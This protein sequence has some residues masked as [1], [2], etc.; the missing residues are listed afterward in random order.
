MNYL[1][2][3]FPAPFAKD[4]PNKKSIWQKLIEA[5]CELFGFKLTPGS[6]LHKE[7]LALGEVIKEIEDHTIENRIKE[8]SQ[9]ISEP[10]K[11]ENRTWY[12]DKTT[13]TRYGRVTT[14]IK[15]SDNYKLFKGEGYELPATS[16]GT[17]V[18]EFVRDFFEGKLDNLTDKE[19]QNNYP[20]VLF[21][22]LFSR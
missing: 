16:I 8:D 12:E 10:N 1:N 11:Y 6:I 14:S 5:V 19:L 17:S 20:N 21:S 3:K 9:N 22:Y 7:Y 18:D 4:A 15:A 2:G 13:G